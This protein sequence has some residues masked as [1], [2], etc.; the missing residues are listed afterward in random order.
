MR[1]KATIAVATIRDRINTYLRHTDGSALHGSQVYTAEQWKFMRLGVCFALE[2]VLHLTGNY[3]G[4][5]YV[6]PHETDDSSRHYN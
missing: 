4:Y 2:E 1:R 6:T 5:G 3:H